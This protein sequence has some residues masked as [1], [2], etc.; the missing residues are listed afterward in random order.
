M[1]GGKVTVEKKE[2][3]PFMDFIQKVVTDTVVKAVD[4]AKDELKVRPPLM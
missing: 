2:D 4:K 3:V 1:L